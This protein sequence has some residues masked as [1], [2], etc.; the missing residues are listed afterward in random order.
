MFPKY[1]AIGAINA[2]LAIALGAFGAHG[3]EKQL[4]D[5]YLEVFETG[6]RYHMYSALGLILISLFAKQMGTS[7]LAL[8]GGRLIL[9]GMIIF[10][11]SLYV[12]S[13]TSFSKLGMI[14]PIGGV[15]IIA[16]WICIITA[17]L[18]KESN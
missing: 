7:K 11:G 12:L 13:I 9:T 10:S 16:G 3:L 4:T 6:V 17:A 8:N 18:K 2:A 5:H 15:A 1:F 14:T